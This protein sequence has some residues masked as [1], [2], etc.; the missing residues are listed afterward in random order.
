MNGKN[1]KIYAKIEAIRIGVMGMMA[2][3][4]E[5]EI[6]N[7]SLAYPESAFED[8]ATDIWML[9]DDIEEEPKNDQ[10]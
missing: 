1:L 6:N 3:N 2:A 10:D 4:K 8:A 9:V 5:R 7:E